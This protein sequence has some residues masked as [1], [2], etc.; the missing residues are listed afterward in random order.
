MDTASLLLVAVIRTTDPGSGG[1]RLPVLVEEVPFEEPVPAAEAASTEGA[2]PSEGQPALD[3]GLQKKVI[4]DLDSAR[5]GLVWS[6]LSIPFVVASW[7]AL[8]VWSEEE[9]QVDRFFA[10]AMVGLA[11][12]TML[13][14]GDALLLRGSLGATSRL[15]QA[16]IQVPIAGGVVGAFAMAGQV[17]LLFSDG[18]PDEVRWPMFF[19]L[20]GVTLAGGWVQI[21][22]AGRALGHADRV[23]VLPAALPAAPSVPAHVPDTPPDGGPTTSPAVLPGA[24]LA[25]RW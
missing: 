22:A 4:R 19:T 10:A 11:G 3:P 18:L 24:M 12:G 17:G 2:I 13:L 25:V 14:A 7:G 23:V 6:G 5:A 15:S 8:G 9:L 16:G 21:R 20:H 1:E